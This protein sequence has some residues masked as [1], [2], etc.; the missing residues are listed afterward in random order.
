MSIANTKD[1]RFHD[2]MSMI[3]LNEIFVICV[4]SVIMTLFIETP[5]NNIKNLLFPRNVMDVN[6]N[7]VVLKKQEKSL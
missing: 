7:D 4:L 2:A 3:N 5:F 6:S 1:I